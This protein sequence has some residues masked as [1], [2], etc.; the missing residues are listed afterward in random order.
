[1]MSALRLYVDE[2][3]SETAV[4]VGSRARGI[5]LVATAEA[6]MLGRS[7]DEQLEFATGEGRALFTYNAADFVR[8]HSET[9]QRPGGTHCGVIVIPSQRYSTGETV[10]RVA[11]FVHGTTSEAMVDQIAFL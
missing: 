9:L 11:S 6:G 2:D 8:I 7:D 3:A 5:D 1:M 10:R 4:I